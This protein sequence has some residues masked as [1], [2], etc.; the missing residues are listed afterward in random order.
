GAAAGGPLTS[1]GRQY[2]N[3]ASDYREQA[4]SIVKIGVEL[5]STLIPL[6]P[7]RAFSWLP[8]IGRAGN[9]TTR[10]A[11]RPMSTPHPE[12]I[13]FTDGTDVSSFLRMQGLELPRGDVNG[14]LWVPLDEPMS[15]NSLAEVAS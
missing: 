5:A 4:P 13:S 10:T 14:N 2:E 11:G 15:S 6:P 3:Y 8:K 12:G 7:L 1:Q 9:T